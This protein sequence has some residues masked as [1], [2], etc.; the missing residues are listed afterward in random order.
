[1]RKDPSHKPPMGQGD[2]FFHEVLSVRL[3]RDQASK[4]GVS[5]SSSPGCRGSGA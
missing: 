4:V 1:M 5:G 3:R 2:P